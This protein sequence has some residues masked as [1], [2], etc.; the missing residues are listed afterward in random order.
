M[1]TT[2][3][4]CP[5][6]GEETPETPR[7]MA[8]ECKRWD[9]DRANADIYTGVDTGKRIEWL[10]RVAEPAELLNSLGDDDTEGR[11]VWL[12]RFFSEIEGRHQGAM[13]SFRKAEGVK[14]GRPL[15]F[16]GL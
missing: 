6:C 12:A 4:R 10:G 1:G 3:V 13:R 11:L 14:K 8:C 9:E 7:H 5:S 15:F 2:L 16:E